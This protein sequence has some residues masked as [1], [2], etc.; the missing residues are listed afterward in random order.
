MT[1]PVHVDAELV[2]NRLAVGPDGYGAAARLHVRP[3]VEDGDVVSVAQQSASNR[4]AAH[5]R[6]YDKNPQRRHPRA[7]VSV[8]RHAVNDVQLRTLALAPHLQ[9]YVTDR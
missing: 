8:R 5:T 9:G 2:K 4:N 1:G 3:L 6:P 7:C